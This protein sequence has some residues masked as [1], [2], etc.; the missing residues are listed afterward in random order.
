MAISAKNA[1]DIKDRFKA[2]MAEHGDD[3][4]FFVAIRDDQNMWR[5]SAK[6]SEG[7]VNVLAKTLRKEAYQT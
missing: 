4:D 5:Y 7:D 2:F 3:V 1:N 6:V